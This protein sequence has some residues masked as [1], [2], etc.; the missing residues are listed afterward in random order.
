MPQKKKNLCKNCQIWHSP[1]TSK[2]CKNARELT[3]DIENEQF[4]DAAVKE[5]RPSTSHND[6]QLVQQKILDQLQT[7]SRRLDQMEERIAEDS[8]P[9]KSHSHSKLSK[10]VLSRDTSNKKNKYILEVSDSSSDECEIPSL[11]KLRSDA[12]QKRVDKRIRDLGKTSDS[13]GK[14]NEQFK[15]KGVEWKFK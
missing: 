4:S 6:R 14:E 3:S 9:K 13:P 7:F 11:Q 1:P 10:N 5:V 8:A 12:L 2:K 15:S